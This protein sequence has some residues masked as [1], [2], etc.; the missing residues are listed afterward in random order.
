[1]RI[2]DR[3]IVAWDVWRHPPAADEAGEI[4]G[5][6]ALIQALGEN[7]L[8]LPADAPREIIVQQHPDAITQIDPKVLQ[9]MGDFYQVVISP[10]MHDR[11]DIT[12]EHPGLVLLEHFARD[13]LCRI[14]IEHVDFEGPAFVDSLSRLAP[15][16]VKVST[17]F[18]MQARTHLFTRNLI[19]DLASAARLWQ[20]ETIV[21]TVESKDD[22]E[23]LDD[24]GVHYAEGKLFD[25]MAI[26]FE[27]RFQS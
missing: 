8:S 4:A 2:Q 21:K 6:I 22:L 14:A 5:D 12:I 23:L 18:L 26:C 24:L 25:D 15:R 3:R 16:W 10:V 11:E 27:V 7:Q 17:L 9:K 13:R 20:A 19:R 1:V